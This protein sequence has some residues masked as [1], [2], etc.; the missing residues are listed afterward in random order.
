MS[1]LLNKLDRHANAPAA[2][3]GTAPVTGTTT[4]GTTRAGTNYSTAG[5]TGTTGRATAGVAGVNSN[6]PGPAPN[7][8]GPHRHD[9]LNKLDP[10]VD[11]DLS[12]AQVTANVGRNGAP[13]SLGR[14]GGAAAT[15][16]P[17]NVNTANSTNVSEGTYGPHKSRL[18]NAL[19]PRVDSDLDNRAQPSG[20]APVAGTGAGLSGQGRVGNTYR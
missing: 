9:V 8:A 19:D 2:T 20:A 12:D 13:V 10:R 4:S 3:R 15:R 1:S 16:A 6:L 18:A 11:S 17:G 14:G 5:T 7:T